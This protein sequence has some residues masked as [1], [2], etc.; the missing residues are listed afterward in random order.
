[1]ASLVHKMLDW[2]NPR[3]CAGSAKSTCSPASEGGPAPSA[4]PDASTEG[5]GHVH[6]PVS[7]SAPQAT[8]EVPATSATCGPTLTA[9]LRSAALQ[10]SLESRL[11]QRTGCSGSSQYVMTWKKSDTPSQRPICRLV[12]S[13]RRTYGNAF[14]GWPTPRAGCG[15]I[16]RLREPSQIRIGLAMRNRTVPDRLEDAV[17]LIHGPGGILNPLWI[18]WLMGYPRNWVRPFICLGTR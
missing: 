14:T 16:R 17:A 5:Y 6:V 8:E 11:R 7:R 13:A 12:A 2:L 9:S 1:M 18:A 10:S 3:N 4:S 15:M